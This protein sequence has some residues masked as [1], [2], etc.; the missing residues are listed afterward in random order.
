MRGESGERGEVLALE[1]GISLI[2][3]AMREG[4]GAV[5]DATVAM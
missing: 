4:V 1:S 3:L 5:E 2:A